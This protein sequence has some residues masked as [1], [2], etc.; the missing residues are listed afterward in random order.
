V[1][2]LKCSIVIPYKQRLDSLRAVLTSLTEQTMSASSFEIVVGAMEYDSAYVSLCQEFTG[3][4]KIVSVLA[5]EAWNL[6]R[7]RN[8]AIR[9]AT[10]EIVVVVDASM[11]L[12]PQV[13][14]NL[15]TR[16][17][18]HGQTVCVLGQLLGYGKPVSLGTSGSFDDYRQTLASVTYAERERLDSRWSPEYA[19]A[20]SRFP[21]AFARTGL[22]ALPNRSIREHD[23]LFDER[24]LGCGPEDQEWG[25]RISAAGIP[26]VLGQDV[27]GLHLPRPYDRAAQDR[28]AV[29]T[30]RYYLAKWPRLDLELALA[31]GGWLEADKMLS[32]V[33]REL[34]EAA[35][36]H[37][38]GIVRGFVGGLSMLA[39]GAILDDEGRVDDPEVDALFP[40][41]A[42]L[43]VLP[44]A[45][46]AIPYGDRSL[47]E[48][49]LLSPVD[50]LG[51]RYR[52]AIH[53]EAERVSQKV[54][55]PAAARRN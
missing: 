51:P 39:V 31:F 37:R 30:N 54:I 9:Q 8:L 50:A 23:L 5:D 48:C 28:S 34:A 32:D 26:I 33:E 18:Q 20:F 40:P 24:F 15:Y 29:L 45:G 42:R 7:A 16:H 41:R 25:L 11:V 22:M 19:S 2:Q 47:D 36:G 17:F 38:L 35:G 44:L 10:G 52:D 55:A 14:D 1:K 21:W 3:Q 27:Y 49:R 4:L 53:R 46:F 6:S 13:L 12:A 43:D